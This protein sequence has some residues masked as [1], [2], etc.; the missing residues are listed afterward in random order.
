MARKSRAEQNTVGTSFNIMEYLAGLYQR[1]SVEDGDDIEQNSIGNQKKIGLHYLTE[2]PDIRF[3]DTYADHG[4]TG[5]NFKRPGFARMLEDL[6]SGRINCVIIKDI[7]RLG[8]HF[9]LTSEYVERIFPGMGVRLI[10]INDGYDSMDEHSDASALTMPLKM[11]MSDYYVKDISKKIRSGISAKMS[12]GTYLPSSSS[13][14][15]GYLRNPET[16]T[17]DI[18]QEPA[19]VVRRIFGMRSEGMSFTSIA[20]TLNKEGI[21]CPGKLRYLR[22]MTKSEVY[23]DAGWLRG[24]VRKMTQDPVYIG[25]RIHG[26]V[27]RD[28]IGMEKRQRSAEEWNVIENAHTPIISK[29]LFDRVQEVNEKELEKRKSFKERVG[30]DTDYREILRGK[31]FCAECGSQMTAAKGCARPNAKTPSRVFYDCN[32]YRDSGHTRCSSHYIRQETIMNAVSNLLNQQVQ[33]GV[34]MERLIED[35]KKMPKVL[36]Y[37]E[38]VG[39][40]HA[41]ISMKRKNMELKMERLLVDLTEHLI[42]KKEYDYIKGRYQEQYEQLLEEEARAGADKANLDTALQTALKWIERLKEYRK[43][44]FIDRR[45]MDLLVDSIYVNHEKQ[46]RIN[47]TYADPYQPLMDYLDKVEGMKHAG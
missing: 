12:S 8:R 18:D 28:K 14:P 36:S 1:L 7:S 44:P 32:G 22:G 11:V 20:R 43:L 46:I 24:T 33:T 31:V 26:R 6:K 30:P 5:M 45:V 23:K 21:P 19:A 42:D 27:K 38:N 25:N 17:Y 41:N 37:Q 13:V 40:R 35:V 2:H 3:V 39:Q 10:S 29:E 16:V 9:V 34:D 4:Y 15:Y 47:L